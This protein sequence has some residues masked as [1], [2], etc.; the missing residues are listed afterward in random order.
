M[1]GRRVAVSLVMIMI[2]GLCGANTL[3]A[4][5][6]YTR[7][8]RAQLSLV[9]ATME[10]HGFDKTH[11]F[12]VDALQSDGTDTF[13]VRLND[14]VEYRIVAVCDHDCG[15]I[16][17]RLFDENANEVAKDTEN[18][19]VPV[20]S[21]TPRWT[22]RFKIHIRMYDCKVSPCFYGIGIFGK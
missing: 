18:D 4:Q 19:D 10:E 13:T 12:Q 11:N 3:L 7:E 17:I 6:R 16:D 8:I 15:D 14:D 9:E 2:S 5:E 21:I 20:V 1:S 22:G